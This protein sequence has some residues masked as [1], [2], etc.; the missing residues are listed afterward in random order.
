[1]TYQAPF[2]EDLSRLEYV[3]LYLYLELLEEIDLPPLALLQLRRE[4]QGALKSY[5]AAASPEKVRLLSA[6]LEPPL[7]VDPE[8]R[9]QVQKPA[10]ALILSPDLDHEDSLPAGTRLRLPV[11]FLGQGLTALPPFLELLDHLGQSGLY[12]GR[13]RFF[14]EAIETEDPS[15]LTA[16]LWTQG[17]ERGELAPP[18]SDLSWWLER[19]NAPVDPLRLEFLTPA[20][21]IHNG[22][23][24]F[25]AGFQ[26]VF[27]FILRRVSQVLYQHLG[28]ETIKNSD[29]LIV[30]AGQVK[31]L[32]N[33]LSWRDW[34]TLE[35][36]DAR[37]QLGGLEGSL[38]LAGDALGEL[39]WVLQ[40]GSLFQIGKGAAYGAGRYRLIKA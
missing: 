26:E 4:L 14:I 21:L 15:G 19:Q 37:Q 6:L 38:D 32:S 27:P 29:E 24:L 8:S 33:R 23:P 7:P 9:K 40:L 12:N 34:R 20:R 17:E 2:P 1:M 3:R 39:W 10:A 25:K 28:R 18:I 30:F 13:G 22:K 11:L 31:T 35:Q 5:S 36:L 16:M